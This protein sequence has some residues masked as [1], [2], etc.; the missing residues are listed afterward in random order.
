MT[1]HAAYFVLPLFIP[2]SLR[3]QTMPSRQL[4]YGVR[5]ATSRN[6]DLDGRPTTAHRH[7]IPAAHKALASGITAEAGGVGTESATA[8][9]RDGTAHAGAYTGESGV[10]APAAWSLDTGSTNLTVGGQPGGVQRWAIIHGA[11]Q[12]LMA[13]MME[14][15]NNAVRGGRAFETPAMTA[16]GRR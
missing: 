13:A 1:K 9:G 10:T 12:R 3:Q 8:V 16:Q 5:A 11:G 14:A 2:L 6:H 7:A 15:A 4:S